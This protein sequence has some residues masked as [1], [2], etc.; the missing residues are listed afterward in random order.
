MTVAQYLSIKYEY[1]NA[2]RIIT[3]GECYAIHNGQRIPEARWKA[4]HRTP[5]KLYYSNDNPDKTKVV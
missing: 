5:D 1:L 2:T 3:G 4:M